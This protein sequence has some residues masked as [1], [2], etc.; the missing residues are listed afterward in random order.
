VLA[1]S[2]ALKQGMMTKDAVAL[3]KLLHE[4]LTYG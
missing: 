1:A 3:Q 2:D 4:D